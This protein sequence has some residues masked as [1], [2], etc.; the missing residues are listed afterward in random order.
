MSDDAD[1]AQAVEELH[2]QNALAALKVHRH[3]TSEGNGMCT[4]CGESIGEARLMAVP[5]AMRCT[6]CENERETNELG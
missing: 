4:S 2:R 1:R 5:T 6:H 3:T